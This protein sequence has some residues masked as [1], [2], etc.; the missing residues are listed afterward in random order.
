MIVRLDN[1]KLTPGEGEDELSR[2]AERRLGAR[3]FPHT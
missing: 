3:V 2:I 1:I